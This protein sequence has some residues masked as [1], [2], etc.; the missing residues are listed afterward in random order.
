VSGLGFG[1]NAAKH[2]KCENLNR[3]LRAVWLNCHNKSCGLASTK[4]EEN[5][6]YFGNKIINITPHH[7]L[8]GVLIKDGF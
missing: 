5:V 2:E 3:N 8:L 1:G 6:I 7:P 4:S